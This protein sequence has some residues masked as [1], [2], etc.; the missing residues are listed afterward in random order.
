MG[1][2]PIGYLELIRSNPNYRRLWIGQV[3]SLFG[4]W[5][6][7][8]AAYRLVAELTGS[9]LA[10]GAV[11]LCKM[12]PLGLASPLAGVLV[13]R[14][15]RR[16]TMIATDLLRA[17]VVL[18]FLVVDD[19][20]EVGLFYVFLA[21]QVVL[22]AVF[23]PA[24]S[25]SVPNVTTPE[26]LL[27]ANAL[28]AATWSTLLAVGAATGGLALE[29]LGYRAVFLLDSVTY[30]VSAFFIARTRIPQRT[31][32]PEPGPVVALALRRIREGWREIR[33]RDELATIVLVK[34]AWSLGGGGLIYTLAIY[35]ELVS[36][37]APAT[38][39]GILFAVRG[40]GTGLGP[41]LARRLLPDPSTWLTWMGRFIVLS[42]VAYLTLAFLPIGWILVVPVLVAHVCS[43]ANW[44]FATVLLQQRA[45]DRLRGRVFATEWLLI[46]TAD[47]V[48]IAAAAW[49]LERGWLNLPGVV[50]VL[51]I[52]QVLC[53]IAWWAVARRRPREVA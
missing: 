43:G 18:G 22:S 24:K 23:L 11:F 33:S 34:A 13:D 12:L 9:P 39:V 26:Q 42:G 45:E 38:G 4:D 19:P 27:T 51:A 49:T 6:N 36:P 35:G 2:E 8:I 17:V 3:V 5:F 41:V 37:T 31:D 14:L 47:A 30:L 25:A 1:P 10:L 7:T 28:S 44:V 16:R 53:G 29:W 46:M 15:D 52:V 32:P 20:S 50:I 21:V 40:A 48:S